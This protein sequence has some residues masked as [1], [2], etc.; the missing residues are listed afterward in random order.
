MND[1]HEF[2]FTGDDLPMDDHQV[3][4][5]LSPP[6]ARITA[7]ATH[8]CSGIDGDSHRANDYEVLL[9]RWL[10]DNNFKI[11]RPSK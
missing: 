11:I 9:H 8:L 2:P 6:S 3:E 1:M 7:L 10:M 4:V 5:P